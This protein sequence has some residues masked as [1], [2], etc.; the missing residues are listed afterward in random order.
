MSTNSNIPNPNIV[1]EINNNKPIQCDQSKAR[2]DCLVG[3]LDELGSSEWWC[4]PFSPYP[5][6]DFYRQRGQPTNMS[7]FTT[8]KGESKAAMGEADRL[9]EGEEQ[10]LQLYGKILFST[11]LIFYNL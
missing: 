8:W 7:P 2:R 5:L 6:D 10:D 9:R 3:R 11:C 1:P 4:L